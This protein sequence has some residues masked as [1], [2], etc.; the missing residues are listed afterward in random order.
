M[1]TPASQLPVQG[2]SISDVLTALQNLVKAINAA[3]QQ[4]LAINGAL[5]FPA[6]SSATVVKM[7]AGR[8]VDIS[9]IAAGTTVGMIYDGSTLAATTKP[10][11]PLP[12][13]VG[14][15]RVTFPVSF[16]ILIIPGAGQ[17]VA[18]SYS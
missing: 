5:N 18:G 16:G 13:I 3:S 17:T 6:I 2:A 14:V 10:I 11:I 7:T 12:N 15:Y 4:Y 1:S 9:I 8:I